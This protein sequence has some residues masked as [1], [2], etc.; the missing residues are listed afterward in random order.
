MKIFKKIID[1]FNEDNKL[2]LKI[3]LFFIFISFFI[4]IIFKISKYGYELEIKDYFNFA[5][6]FGGAILGGIISLIIL[7]TT[8]AKQ[9]QQFDKQRKIE[10]TRREEDRNQFE[11]QLQHE[12]EKFNK[13]YNIK[14]INDKVMQY[15]ELHSICSDSLFI[16][17]KIQFEVNKIN[18]KVISRDKLTDFLYNSE[19]IIKNYYKNIY[20]FIFYSSLLNEEENKRIIAS[21]DELLENVMKLFV[22]IKEISNK[23]D[24]NVNICNINMK[25]VAENL[26]EFEKYLSEIIKEYDNYI[27]HINKRCKELNDKKMIVS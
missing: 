19:K 7:K 16:I 23:Y 1:F 27:N 5:G 21:R 17:D 25:Y 12:K 6:S 14:I 26:D 10:D 20:S 18:K 11:K 2:Y 22:S 24:N 13:E 8:L 3:F 9:E 15:K 4:P